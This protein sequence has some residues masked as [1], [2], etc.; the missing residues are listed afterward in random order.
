M[1][2]SHEHTAIHWKSS[3]LASSNYF[4]DIK[5]YTGMEHMLCN[6]F[7]EIFFYINSRFGLLC[8]LWYSDHFTNCDKSW[9]VCLISIVETLNYDY[10]Y[11]SAI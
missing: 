10:C 3:F 6:R 7:Y 2:T 4:W 5:E 9:S 11:I 1:E 8:N